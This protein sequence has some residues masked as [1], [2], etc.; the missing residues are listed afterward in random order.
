MSALAPVTAVKTIA[1][2]ISA[3]FVKRINGSLNFDKLII[4]E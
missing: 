3:V 4:Y 1:A 2:D